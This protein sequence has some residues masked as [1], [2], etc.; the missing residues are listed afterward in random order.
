M[1]QKGDM[2]QVPYWGSTNIRSHSKKFGRHGD[3]GLCTPGVAYI[4]YFIP[5]KNIYSEL[6]P[7]VYMF[8]LFYSSVMPFMG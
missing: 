4:F 7:Q 5:E 1:R 6:F 8:V 2:K 3:R